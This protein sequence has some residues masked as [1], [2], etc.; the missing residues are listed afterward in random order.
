MSAD[1]AI[2]E[3]KALESLFKGDYVHVDEVGLRR[4]DTKCARQ[5]GDALYHD[6]YPDDPC[7]RIHGIVT[8]NAAAGD[9]VGVLIAIE[10]A[11]P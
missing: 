1:R 8:G 11:T 3:H 4:I 2:I 6:K 5:I 10:G 7:M 9:N